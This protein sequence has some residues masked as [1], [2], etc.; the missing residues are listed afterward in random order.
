MKSGDVVLAVA[1]GQLRR[2]HVEAVDPVSLPF[3]NTLATKMGTVTANSVYTTT[4][5]EG[6][7][8]V[9]EALHLNA[10]AALNE[11]RLVHGSFTM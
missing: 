7:E 10:S 6:L 1:H 2:G 11:W 5:C 8:V 4:I 3:K 9:P